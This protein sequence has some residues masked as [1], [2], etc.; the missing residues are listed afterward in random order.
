MSDETAGLV[1]PPWLEN[2]AGK[3]R[4]VGVELEMTG[5]EL[6]ALAAHL[7]DFLGLHA[8]IIGRYERVLKGDPDGDWLVE[9]DFDLLKKLGRERREEGTMSAEIASV[10]EDALAWAAKSLVPVEVISPPLPLERLSQF[11]GLIERLR[12]AGAKGTSDSAIN[13]FGLQFN[14]ELPS[15]EPRLI[16]CALKAFVCLYDW[17]YERADIDMSRRV[18]SYVNPYPDDY[19]RKIIAADYWPGLS[20]LMDD[21]LAY[22]PTRNRALDMLPLFAYLDEDRV[23]AQTD[24]ELI[25]ARPTFHYRLPDCDIH[26]P[27]WGL[28]FAWNDWVEVER[29]AVDEARLQACCI[30]YETHLGSPLSRVCSNWAEAVEHGWL[31]R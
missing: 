26:K 15:F 9:L 20:A 8:R 23:L 17:L 11:E 21:Y 5:I 14:P 16:A 18:T 12:K 30:A 10:A 27:D 28:Q 2:A 29:L 7:A 31:N 3:P 6:D 19:V 4:R 13:A 25:K 22:N 24:D 1:Q